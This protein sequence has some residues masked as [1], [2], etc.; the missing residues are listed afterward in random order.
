MPST[1]EMLVTSMPFVDGMTPEDVAYAPNTVDGLVILNLV[2]IQALERRLGHL[3]GLVHVLDK[4]VTLLS[5]VHKAL[6]EPTSD[7]QDVSVKKFH[8]RCHLYWAQPEDHATTS[9]TTAAD[10]MRTCKIR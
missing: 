1:L 3:F 9:A 4:L 6:T 8:L 5:P 2:V 10:A 7:L